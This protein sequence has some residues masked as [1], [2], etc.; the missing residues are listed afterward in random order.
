[1][2][3]LIVILQKYRYI[4][5]ANSKGMSDALCGRDKRT[6]AIAIADYR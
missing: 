4:S 1:M 6:V 2:L 3:Y 5:K